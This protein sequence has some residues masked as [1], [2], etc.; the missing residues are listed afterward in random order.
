MEREC[1]KNVERGSK[2]KVGRERRVREKFR[3]G[4]ERER[5]EKGSSIQGSHGRMFF[6]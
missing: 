5:S 1:E 3:E 4:T 2:E 6:L